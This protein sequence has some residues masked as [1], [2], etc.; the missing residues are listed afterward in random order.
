MAELAQQRTQLKQSDTLA[1]NEQSVPNGQIKELD[2]ISLVCLPE[3]GLDFEHL[4]LWQKAAC[5]T[6]Y[7]ISSFATGRGILLKEQ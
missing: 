3:H 1:E 7:C 5:Y 2:A 4:N 6:F